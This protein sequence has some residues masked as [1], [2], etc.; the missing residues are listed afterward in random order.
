MGCAGYVGR[1]QC[2]GVRMHRSG[3]SCYRE[4]V[5]ALVGDGVA[6]FPPRIE[7]L[8]AWGTM[9]RCRGTFSNYLGYAKV[10]CLL[11]KED[12]SVFQ[13]PAVRRAKDS[14][15]KSGRFASREKLWI[16]RDR[17]EALLKLAGVG[18]LCCMGCSSFVF[19]G[20]VR[21]TQWRNASQCYI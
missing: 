4:F 3:I 21:T 11:A 14:V 1:D 2:V 9:F 20:F 13:H 18:L 6:A 19:V 16:Q 17:I 15:G 10:G 5:K 8:Q 12:T 7:W